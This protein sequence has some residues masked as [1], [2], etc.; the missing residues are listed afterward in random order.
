M[1]TM[2]TYNDAF[3]FLNRQTSGG[4][5]RKTTRGGASRPP[6]RDPRVRSPSR[7]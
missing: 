6:K 1:G 7:R 5:S 4:A 2:Q 3:R